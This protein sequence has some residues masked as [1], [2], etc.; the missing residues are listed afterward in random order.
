VPNRAGD[1]WGK[2]IVSRSLPMKDGNTELVVAP[3]SSGA[4]GLARMVPKTGARNWLTGS[5]GLGDKVA[6][7][8]NI[9]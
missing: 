7:Q 2:V 1:L 6:R 8:K 3:T 4:E 5:T 9:K